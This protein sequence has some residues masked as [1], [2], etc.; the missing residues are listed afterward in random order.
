M[1]LRPWSPSVPIYLEICHY[2]GT[3]KHLFIRPIQCLNIMVSKCSQLQ[4]G[5]SL[6]YSSTHPHSHTLK[7][8]IYWNCYTYVYSNALT[9]IFWLQL[10]ISPIFSLVPSFL[11]NV[12]LHLMVISWFST[13][14]FS[15]NP[16]TLSGSNFF[17]SEGRIYHLLYQ[18]CWQTEIATNTLLVAKFNWYL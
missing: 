13:L 15:F 9:A 8:I 3:L 5:S 17:S 10:H 4:D 14:S 7:L 12:F 11:P 2:P 16:Q 18:T 6:L 1:K